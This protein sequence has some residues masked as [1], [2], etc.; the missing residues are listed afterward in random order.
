[1]YKHNI[2]NIGNKKLPKIALKSSQNQLGLKRCGCKD[3]IAWL[4]HWGLMKTTFCRTLI[5]SKIVLLLNFYK[6]CGATKIYQLMKI[7]I[8]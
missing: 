4:D 5:M 7:K 8:L 6:N 1:M 2:N 3:T